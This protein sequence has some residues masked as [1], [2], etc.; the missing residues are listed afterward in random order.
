MWT[1]TVAPRP[2]RSQPCYH[3]GM[4]PSVSGTIGSTK[5]I[6]NEEQL[7]CELG[8]NCRYPGNKLPM[9]SGP[10]GLRDEG[11]V[12]AWKSECVSLRGIFADIN[13]LSLVVV[14]IV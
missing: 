9:D 12:H 3:T 10:N 7:I 4:P 11:G 2:G 1:T 13:H 6:V 8:P 14:N 5:S